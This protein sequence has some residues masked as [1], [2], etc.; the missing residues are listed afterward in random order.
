VADYCLVVVVGYYYFLL[1]HCYCSPGVVDYCSP[2][3]FAVLVVVV[4]AE[5]PIVSDNTILVQTL[6]LAFQVPVVVVALALVVVEYLP[7]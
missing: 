2:V 6:L 5:A 7:L 3:K 1:I 4:V